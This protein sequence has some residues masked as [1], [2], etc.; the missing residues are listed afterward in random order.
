M[1]HIY[2]VAIGQPIGVVLTCKPVK[3][4][5]WCTVMWNVSNFLDILSFA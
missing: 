3:K 2:Y 4:I 1:L 5:N